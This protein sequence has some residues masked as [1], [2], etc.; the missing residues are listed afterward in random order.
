MVV[1]RESKQSTLGIGS[2]IET[3]WEVEVLQVIHK[4]W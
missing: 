4:W 3:D 1:S 2:Y